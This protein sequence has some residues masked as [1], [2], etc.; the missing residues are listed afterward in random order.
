MSNFLLRI[1]T[2]A[3]ATEAITTRRTTAIEAVPVAIVPL[4]AVVA[5]VSAEAILEVAPCEGS[6]VEEAGAVVELA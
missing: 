6:G 3:P 2:A 4:P 5:A 1:T